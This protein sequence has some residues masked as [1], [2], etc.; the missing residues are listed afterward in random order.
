MKQI[1]YAAV[2]LVTILAGCNKNWDTHYGKEEGTVS[3]LNLLDYLKSQPQYSD[4]VAK[5]EEYDLAEALK[6]DQNLTV[7]AVS[8]ENM[9]ALEDSGEDTQFILRY[10]INSLMYDNTKLKS[11]LR[12][13]T[14]NGKY[15][16]I[17]KEGPAIRIGDAT[18]V[19]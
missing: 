3:P 2:C 14:F 4:F 6:R 18:V 19:K 12:V 11:G 7:W 15:V 16:S 13:L 9:G 5:L 8:N 1:L 10:H 17:D